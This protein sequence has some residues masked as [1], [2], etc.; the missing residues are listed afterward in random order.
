MAIMTNGGWFK[1]HATKISIAKS[2]VLPPLYKPVK[3]HETDVELAK[4]P[5]DQYK[6]REY[7]FEGVTVRCSVD[8]EVP[9]DAS[10]VAIVY[11]E[12]VEDLE[13]EVRGKKV[14]YPKGIGAFRIYRND[15]TVA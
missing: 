13:V 11:C 9:Q 14:K 7:T 10:L 12:S 5:Q 2:S 15:I 1:E 4:L 8:T 6:R 3:I